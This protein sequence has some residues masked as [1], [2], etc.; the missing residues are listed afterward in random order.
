MGWCSFHLDEPVKDWFTRSWKSNDLYEV[1]EVALVKRTT[2]YAAVKEKLT[3]DVF[4]VVYLV[5]WSRDW[6]NFCYKDMTEHSGP[7]V[8]DCPEKIFKLLTPLEDNDDNRFAIDWRK[9]V[10]QLHK[11]RKLLKGD[12]IVKVAAPISFNNGMEISYFQKVGKSMYG[13]IMENEK[14]LPYTRVRK[15]SLAT[16][17]FEIIK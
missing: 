17:E 4:C 13:G 2:I 5:R 7:N 9:R 6:F 3:G 11:N 16:R 12:C 10:S 8:H 14:F 1:L 15:F